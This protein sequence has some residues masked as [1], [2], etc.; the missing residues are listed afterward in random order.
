MSLAR[1]PR[2]GR[3]HESAVERLDEAMDEQTRRRDAA[4]DARGTADQQAADADLREAE[5]R[6][7]GR[8][9]WL[10]WIE[11]GF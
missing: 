7:T 1:P 3:V 6:V 10:A 4:Q 8:E 11:R 2:D 5:H 9:A